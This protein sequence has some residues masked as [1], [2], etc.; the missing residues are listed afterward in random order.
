M[1]PKQQLEKAAWEWTEKTQ[2]ENVSY[3]NMQAAYRLALKPCELNSCRYFVMSYP[4]DEL[5]FIDLHKYT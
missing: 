5:C 1:A 3:N 2:P 4:I